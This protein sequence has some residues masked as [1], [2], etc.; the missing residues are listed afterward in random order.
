VKEIRG[1]NGRSGMRFD[2]DGVTGNDIHYSVPL[3]TM[4]Y[5]IMETR[6]RN[7]PT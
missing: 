4:V 2:K 7:H 5:E 1:N 3:G 6:T